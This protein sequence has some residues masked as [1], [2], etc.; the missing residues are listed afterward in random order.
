MREPH[1]LLQISGDF[2][3][4]VAVKI[5]KVD[6]FWR[7][8]IES[9]IWPEKFVAER[10]NVCKELSFSNSGNWPDSIGLSDKS[11]SFRFFSCNILFG[12]SPLIKHELNW[13][14]DKYEKFA[15]NSGTGEPKLLPSSLRY[16]IWLNWLRDWSKGPI[17]EQ[18]DMLRLRSVG[19]NWET[20][21]PHFDPSDEMLTPSR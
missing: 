2:S 3:M 16:E 14:T 4:E 10:I 7:L 15:K 6:R 9:G 5:R 12:N 17:R 11:I 19:P 13:R 8:P 1:K 20:A 18:T 21:R